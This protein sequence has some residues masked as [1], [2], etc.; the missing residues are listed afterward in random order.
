MLQL[1]GVACQTPSASFAYSYV[2]V[3]TPEATPLT[4]GSAVTEVRLTVPRRYW[5]GSFIVAV[6]T[7]LSIIRAVTG[8]ADA[9]LPARS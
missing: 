9:E 6:G 5:P 8:D 4:V 3:A 1:A 2:T 7:V